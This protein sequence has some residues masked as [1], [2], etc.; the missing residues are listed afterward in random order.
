VKGSLK[1]LNIQL[2]TVW[3]AHTGL[4]R[5]FEEVKQT[6]SNHA[7][8]LF[9]LDHATTELD[10][11]ISAV[12]INT[13]ACRRQT[14]SLEEHIVEIYEQNALLEKSIGTLGSNKRSLANSSPWTTIEHNDTALTS[15]P[16]AFSAA[17]ERRAAIE[18]DHAFLP[19]AV[20]EGLAAAEK[21]MAVEKEGA[22]LVSESQAFAAIHKKLKAIEKEFGALPCR[23]LTMSPIEIEQM[24]SQSTSAASSFFCLGS[25]DSNEGIESIQ[26]VSMAAGQL[27]ND[28]VEGAA[29]NQPLQG[30]QQ[31][32]CVPDDAD[33]RLIARQNF[34]V[35]MNILKIA[36]KKRY[37]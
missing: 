33:P 37:D 24:Q 3:H 17:Y 31:S 19:S 21:V 25:D 10:G 16:K 20:D 18:R 32:G 6:Q 36:R 28:D 4:T 22:W 11:T 13:D 15:A 1:E 30:K 29:P 12:N 23:H 2:E 5:N 7:S 8:L 27:D 34:E 26:A 35:A 9:D 14:S